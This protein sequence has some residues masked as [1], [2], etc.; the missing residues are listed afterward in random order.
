MIL[1][2]LSA[3]TTWKINILF[4]SVLH[5]LARLFGTGYTS[6]NICTSKALKM[7]LSHRSSANFLRKLMRYMENNNNNNNKKIW[8]KCHERC[9]LNNKSTTYKKHN[10]ASSIGWHRLHALPSSCLMYMSIYNNNKHQRHE[11][12]D[13]FFVPFGDDSYNPDDP[14]LS[15]Y[16][17]S[18]INVSNWVRSNSTYS[19]YEYRYTILYYTQYAHNEVYV[20]HKRFEKVVFFW[21]ISTIKVYHDIYI[22]LWE[23]VPSY[24]FFF[25]I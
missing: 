21:R 5:I 25:L 22:W 23:R 17:L 15:I 7:I 3:S 2:N 11:K 16:S 6:A 20:R 24:F 12:K 18:S 14:Y 8:R 19:P 1:L 10:A 4:E 9:V 13:S